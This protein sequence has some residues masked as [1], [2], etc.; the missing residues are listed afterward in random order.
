[1]ADPTPKGSLK[2]QL[3]AWK[4]SR[5]EPP[6]AAEKARAKR[7]AEKP[8][9]DVE[10]PAAPKT[11]EELFMAAV[12]DVGDGAAAILEKYGHGEAPDRAPD[13]AGRRAKRSLKRDVQ[14]AAPEV[15]SEAA[16]RRMFL[17]AVEGASSVDP[18]GR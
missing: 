3:K 6:A 5:P 14:A 2:D 15:D 4:A 13:A 11:D 16:E 1:M 8:E 9:P 7:A 10:A 17:D 12:A 18:E